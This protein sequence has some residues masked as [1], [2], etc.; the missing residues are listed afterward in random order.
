MNVSNIEA[1]LAVARS[2]GFTAVARDRNVAPSSISRSI[3]ALEEELGVRL[4]HRTTRVMT[5]TEAGEVFL[6]KSSPA[7]EELLAAKQA[8]QDTRTVATG[9]LKISASVAFGTIV[10]MP[11][12][13]KFKEK[14]PE[15]SLELL[16]SDTVQD[17][18]AEGIDLA[19]RHGALTDSTLIC[20]QYCDVKYY[21]VANPD[22]IK[23]APPLPTPADLSNHNVINFTLPMFKN[24]W[25][26]SNGHRTEDIEI[27]PEITCSSPMA[28][29]QS[30]RLGLGVALLA[31]WM[32]AKDLANGSLSRL[33]DGHDIRGRVDET[34]VWMI[35]P[36]KKFVP[37]K[38]AL[39]ETF[40]GKDTD[41]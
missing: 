8:V 6:K 1:F 20:R 22:Y 25:R 12:I 3:Q 21:L 26:F 18:V 9:H 17:I 24:S 2:G 38:V 37:A 16:F 29:L 28:I 13:K 31:D 10:L 30:V 32:V 23:R 7:I 33:L 34:S 36:S 35:R 14:Y 5:L 15:I 41:F 27:N 4:F 11:I 40:I 19:F 39:L